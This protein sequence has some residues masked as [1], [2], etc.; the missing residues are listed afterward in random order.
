MMLDPAQAG[1]APALA[2]LGVTAVAIH[3]GGAG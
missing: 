3:P 1:T 2:L